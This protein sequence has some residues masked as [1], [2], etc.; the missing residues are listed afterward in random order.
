MTY[1]IF[2]D[3]GKLNGAGECRQLTEGV[4]NLEVSEELYNL[5]IEAP[6][7]YIYSDG[8]IVDNPNYEAEQAQARENAFNEEFFNTSLGYI[9]REVTMKDGAT[10]AF[11]TDIL[12]LLQVGIPI[13]SYDKPDFTTTDL[14]IQN[15]NK[16]VTEEFINEC[17][18]QV[19]RDFYGVETERE[20]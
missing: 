19:L 7:K 13:I 2:L 4:E 8:E 15:T 1:Y 12:P 11:L 17:K 3:N 20:E 9:R 14:P 6:E 5:F 10:K 16:I 18:Q